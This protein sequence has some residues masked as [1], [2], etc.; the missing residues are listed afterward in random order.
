MN[1]MKKLCCTLF[2]I[3]ALAAETVSAK[4]T[5]PAPD[6][7][8]YDC[9]VQSMTGVSQPYISGKFIVFSAPATARFIGIVFDF[10]NYRTIHAFKLHRLTDAD[11]KTTDSWYFYLLERPKNIKTIC[12]RIIVDGLWTTDPQNSTTIFDTKAGILLSRLDITVVDQPVT[13]RKTDGI[14]RFICHAPSGEKIRLAGS[15]TNWDSW[16]YELTEVLPGQYEIDLPLPAG[17]YYYAYYRGMTSF[18]DDTN[19]LKGYTSDGR[20]ASCITIN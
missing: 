17:T 16:I 8:D 4:E 2:F 11:N 18:I 7:Y 15:F 3:F 13:E 5:A 1:I 12:Y 10:E 19:P 20:T 9:I 6:S 14:T